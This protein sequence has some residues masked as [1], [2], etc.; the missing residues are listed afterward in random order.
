MSANRL[1][2]ARRRASR[3]F[4]LDSRSSSLDLEVEDEDDGHVDSSASAIT[5]IVAS[6]DTFLLLK[7]LTI[8]SMHSNYGK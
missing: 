3:S 2:I 5:G 1:S 8:V 7:N 4:R 6:S